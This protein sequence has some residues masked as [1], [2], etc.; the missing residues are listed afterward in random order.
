MKILQI[1]RAG[2]KSSLCERCLLGG[3]GSLCERCLLG[4]KGSLVGGVH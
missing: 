4:G 1:I 3:K 2:E